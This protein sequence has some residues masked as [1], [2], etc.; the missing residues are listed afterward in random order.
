DYGLAVETTYGRASQALLRAA[1]VS[2]EA[3]SDREKVAIR[4]SVDV[5]IAL[6][7]RGKRRVAF[8]YGQ[9]NVDTAGTLVTIGDPVTVMRDSTLRMAGRVGVPSV[10]YPWW[11]VYGVDQ[12]YSLYDLQDRPGEKR[13]R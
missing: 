9:I 7:N 6:Y 12:N 8:S 10:T 1:G 2:L 13:G 5:T 4:D 11:L 3:Y